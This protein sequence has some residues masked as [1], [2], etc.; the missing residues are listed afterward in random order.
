MT[1][2]RI[3]PIIDGE[4]T[5]YRTTLQVSLVDANRVPVIGLTAADGLTTE[6]QSESLAAAVE[7]DLVPQTQI[8]LLGGGATWYKVTLISQAGKRLTQTWYIQVPDSQA[9]QELTD[10]IGAAAIDPASITAQLMVTMEGH[11]ATAGASASAAAGSAQTASTQAGRAADEADDAEGFATAASG[12]AN[13]ASLSSA[14]AQNWATKTDGEVET[15]QGYGAKKYAQDADQS[16]ADASDSADLAQEWATKT[17]AEV[18][19]GEGY[20]AK[21]YAQDAAQSAGD[22]SGSADLAQEWATKTAAE[23]ETGQGYG[24]KKYAQ[25]ASQSA[26]DASD[27]ADLAQEW[28]TKVDAEVVSGQGYGAKKYAADA[29]Q[30]ASNA[31]GSADLAQDWATK[32]NGEV[33]T[34]QGYGAKKYAQDASQSASDASGY[35]QAAAGSADTASGQAS[36]A[37]DST[38]LA[39][40]WA[41]KTA[42]EVVQGQGY[43]AKKYAEDAAASA[44]AA[45]AS[46]DSFDDRYLGSKSSAPS[47]D[48]DGNN[49][50]T[51]ALYWNSTNGAMYVWNG[52]AWVVAADNLVTETDA[53]VLADAQLQDGLSYALDL[54]LQAARE[55]PGVTAIATAAA[56][57]AVNALLATYENTM[58]TGSIAIAKAIDLAGQ[59]AR[60]IAGGRVNLS[61]G[62]ASEPALSPLGGLDTG[63]W[64]PAVNALALSTAG[65]ERLRLSS[66]GLLGLG[67]NAPSCLLDVNG[68]KLRLRTAKTPSAANDT[69]SAGEVCWDASY[70]YVC[71]ATNTWKRA[72]IATW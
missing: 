43:G 15:G 28:A 24:A 31:S 57:A 19:T 30:S 41:T 63:L 27:S 49:L 12:S 60:E 50:A 1:T 22:A 36:A 61:L 6:Y 21:K 7:I 9:T 71:T 35:A 56:L 37:S 64:F 62:A 40:N 11:V 33:E 32:T 26:G 46:Y 38:T 13:N 44:N 72:A 17:A 2:V 70:V 53:R 48:N 65:V 66:T 14:L 10:L 34:G 16:A 59:V 69:G 45:A 42:S 29:S 23:V 5:V 8:A 39:Q 47:K 4:G 68:D 3:P 51:G 55:L 58:D 52:S 67:T 25:D 54:A 20:G 18:A